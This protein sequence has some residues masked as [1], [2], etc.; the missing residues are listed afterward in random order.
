MYQ[1]ENEAGCSEDPEA[2][3]QMGRSC[4][5]ILGS[6]VARAVF[7]LGSRQH[8]ALPVNPPHSSLH[9]ATGQVGSAL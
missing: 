7:A 5:W 6:F 9:V 4:Q 1:W 3:G 2:T 8:S